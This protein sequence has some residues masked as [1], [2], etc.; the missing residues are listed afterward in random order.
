MRAEGGDG[1]AHSFHV[2]ASSFLVSQVHRN[3]TRL[4]ESH[5]ELKGCREEKRNIETEVSDYSL[6]HFEQ[7]Q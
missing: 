5:A 6:K 2:E 3:K 1:I 7:L 4:P